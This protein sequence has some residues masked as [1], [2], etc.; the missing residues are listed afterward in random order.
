MIAHPPT[1]T[2]PS[3]T[4]GGMY[5]PAMSSPT[6]ADH[7][8]W[9]HAAIV[10]TTSEAYVRRTVRSGGDAW[11]AAGGDTGESSASI[12]RSLSATW[13]RVQ[14]TGIALTAALCALY[15]GNRRLLPHFPSL[16]GVEGGGVSTW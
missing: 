2:R 13:R 12:V 8:T 10:M 16:S 11:T 7:T 15:P 14:R 6:T 4:V 1:Y 9:T 3:A 5:I